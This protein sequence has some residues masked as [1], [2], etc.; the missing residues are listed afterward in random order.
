[1]ISEKVGLKLVLLVESE[2]NPIPRYIHYTSILNVTGNYESLYQL[3][4]YLT[5]VQY[6]FSSSGNRHFK[7]DIR[8][9]SKKKNKAM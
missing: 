2:V 4:L 1:M 5:H 8:L 7:D 6:Q 3:T 9:I